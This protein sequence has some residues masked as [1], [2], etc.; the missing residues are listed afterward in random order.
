MK[1]EIHDDIKLVYPNADTVAYA[2]R[3]NVQADPPLELLPERDKDEKPYRRMPEQTTLGEELDRYLAR[4]VTGP[5]VATATIPP[6]QEKEVYMLKRPH[7]DRSTFQEFLR[8]RAEKD[9]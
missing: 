2:M 1:D 6:Q 9:G 5:S 8:R 3:H 4:G 7:S